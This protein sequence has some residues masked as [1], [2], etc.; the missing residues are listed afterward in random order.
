MEVACFSI[1]QGSLDTLALHCLF[2]PVQ[3]LFSWGPW[4]LTKSPFCLL[5]LLVSSTDLQ[6]P[7]AIT[8]Q[9]VH[10]NVLAGPCA[11]PILVLLTAVMFSPAPL[12][13]G[14]LGS[15]HHREGFKLRSPTQWGF[16]SFQLSFSFAAPSLQTHSPVF[17]PYA[18][19]FNKCWSRHFASSWEFND[20]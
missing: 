9:S 20:E 3:N 17:S 4:H 11:S 8:F 6:A 16:I 18:Y 7:L 15:C 13:Q 14:S 19:L 1:A 10:L 2:H 12:Q 5:S